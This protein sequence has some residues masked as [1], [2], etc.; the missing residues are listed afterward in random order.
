MRQLTRNQKQ[1]LEM[2]YHEEFEEGNRDEVLKGFGFSK[3][4]NQSIHQYNYFSA[5]VY[6]DING[7]DEEV[8]IFGDE[9]A[10][11]KIIYYVGGENSGELKLF[12]D[13][14]WIYQGLFN[15]FERHLEESNE[16]ED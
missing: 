8:L 5:E 16:E 1:M 4:N 15:R 11:D 9:S 13:N 10:K 6:V 7:I 12:Y 14:M 3:V 2:Y